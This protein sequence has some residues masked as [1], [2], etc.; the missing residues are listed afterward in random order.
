MT[1]VQQSTIQCQM[2]LSNQPTLIKV[3]SP[4]FMALI[5]VS[6]ALEHGSVAVER[7]YYNTESSD[8]LL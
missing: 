4:F 8:S 6:D 1:T 2:F 7:S 3:S 5:V